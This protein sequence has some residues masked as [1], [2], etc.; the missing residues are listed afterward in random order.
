MYYLYGIG[1]FNEVAG[2][3]V[4]SVWI[5]CLRRGRRFRRQ[6]L[7]A[8]IIERCL[9]WSEFWLSAGNSDRGVGLGVPALLLGLALSSRCGELYRFADNRSGDWPGDWLHHIIR[10]VSSPLIRAV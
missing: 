7:F 3:D 1:A 2:G 5:P 6:L 4:E 10:R 9:R 8:C